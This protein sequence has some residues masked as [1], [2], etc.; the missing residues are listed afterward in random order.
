MGICC[1]GVCWSATPRA[2]NDLPVCTHESDPNSPRKSQLKSKT[3]DPKEIIRIDVDGDGKPDI[4]ETWWNGKRV[5][6]INEDGKMKWTDVRGDMS[7][8]ALQI[9]RDGDGYYDGPGDLNIKWADD[10]GDGK[11]DVECFAA[12]PSDTAK[13]THAGLSHW[14]VFLDT[15]H[16]GVLGYI[17]WN[18]FEFNR[19]N[20][21]VPPTTFPW[22]PQPAPDFSPDYNGN[23]IFLKQHLPAWVSSD[24]RYNWENPFAFYDFDDDGCTEMSV[25]LL[26]T[27]HKDG[28]KETYS[29]FSSDAYCSMD[30]P[31]ES[32][33]NNEMAYDFTIRFFSAADGSKGDRIDYHNYHN[34]HPG[35]K[36]PRWVL[37]GHYF[38]YDNWRR[39]DEFLHVPHEKCF[40][41]MWH[42]TWG[43]CWMTFDED[44]DNHRWEREEL[45][46]PTDDVYSTA[47][48]NKDHKGGLDGHPQS[49]SL[50]DRGEWDED[51]SGKG[52]LYIGAW[53]QKLHLFGAEKGAWTVDEHA[54]YWGSSPVVG[55][56]SPLVAPKVGEVVQYRDTDNNGYFDEI[57]YDY[58]GDRKVDLKI[59]L[60][61]YA[62]KENPHPDVQPLYNPGKL[63]WQGMHELY[64]KMAFDSYEE[65]LALYRAIW[66]K[67]LNTTE[68]DDLCYA[69]SQG[70]RYD[71]GYWL[72]EKIFR[73]LDQRL[74]SDK[75]TQS[76]LR[77]CYFTHDLAGVTKIIDALDPLPRQAE[78]KS[79]WHII[80]SRTICCAFAVCLLARIGLAQTTRADLDG[81]FSTSAAKMEL[82]SRTDFAKR[83]EAV[84]LQRARF[85]KR[86]A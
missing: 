46:Y 86:A 17:D 26:D 43:S 1:G 22:R 13:T 4:L 59:N 49:D 9:D 82:N 15:D 36:A 7:G 65:A 60:L 56:S 31:N 35:L 70:E 39:I 52:Q 67:G 77:R 79:D 58:D 66:K 41:E 80:M 71:H 24:P 54:Q 8:D 34:K 73:A 84:L 74:A 81:P 78:A 29:G 40:D 69:A 76:E 11:P 75:A 16:D 25:R 2:A 47:R 72:K 83:V 12:N 20:W 63:K 30:L 44:G 61:D 85:L 28:D 57:T 18:T 6:W 5:R 37:D 51:N 32:T 14:M 23:S 48:W 62:T 10:D 42:T 64:N 45:Y 33:R 19:A 68:M 55:T 27:T 53:D 38:R 50:G 3:P 21:R